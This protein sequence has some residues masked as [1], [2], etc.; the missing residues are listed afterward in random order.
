MSGERDWESDFHKLLKAAR[1]VAGGY[2]ATR[3]VGLDQGEDTAA[4]EMAL[5]SL[6]DTCEE[7]DPAARVPASGEPIPATPDTTDA[8]L[9][10]LSAQADA[11]MIEHGIHQAI[12]DAAHAGGPHKDR[13]AS[14]ID[15]L[16]R[17]AFIEG[18]YLGR[19]SL[20]DVPDHGA[21]RPSFP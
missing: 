14:A 2:L 7:L 6:V 9:D 15:G 18:A 8:A 20:D 16:V 3:I 19:T 1:L 21:G 5:A 13:L 10:F 11:W 17:Q 12:G 4:G